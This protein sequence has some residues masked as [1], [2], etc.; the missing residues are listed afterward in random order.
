MVVVVVGVV[1]GLVVVVVV[2]IGVVVGVVVVVVVGDGVT[3]G[4]GCSIIPSSGTASRH[5]RVQNLPVKLESTDQKYEVRFGPI[6]TSR[7]GTLTVAALAL[8]LAVVSAVTSISRPSRRRR[9]S[10]ATSRRPSDRTTAT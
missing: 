10:A 8:P 3:P 2:G 9:N 4:S 5:V 6:E 1:V 7:S